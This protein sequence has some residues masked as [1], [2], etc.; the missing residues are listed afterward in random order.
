MIT[1]ETIKNAAHDLNLKK[2]DGSPAYQKA[3][4]V[5]TAYARDNKASLYHVSRI[6]PAALAPYAEKVSA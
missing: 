5:V 2:A 4:R 6:E 1:L 3:L